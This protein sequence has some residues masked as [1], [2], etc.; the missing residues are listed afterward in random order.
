LKTL[1]IL[2]SIIATILILSFLVAVSYGQIFEDQ[3]LLCNHENECTV[4]NIDD[5]ISRDKA[6]K[7]QYNFEHDLD[8]FDLRGE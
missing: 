4:I 7:I 2:S 8:T 1:I 5:Y 6:D 3:Y